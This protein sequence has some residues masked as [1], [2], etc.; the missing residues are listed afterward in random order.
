M[1][2]SLSVKQLRKTEVRSWDLFASHVTFQSHFL[3]NCEEEMVELDHDV[4]LHT[5]T[6]LPHQHFGLVVAQKLQLL[7]LRQRL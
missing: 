5:T 4:W 2:F 3:G 6:V 1:V 7:A